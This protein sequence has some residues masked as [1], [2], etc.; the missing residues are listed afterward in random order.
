MCVH[1]AC[2]NGNIRLT[3]KSL[4]GSYV[5]R[6]KKKIYK[7]NTDNVLWQKISSRQTN[8]NNVILLA[9]SQR[10]N[11]N[12]IN[13]NLTFQPYTLFY[14]V[15]KR[16]FSTLD[17]NYPREVFIENDYCSVKLNFLQLSKQV[18]HINNL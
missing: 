5:N 18:A 13:V 3:A 6:V 12:N 8:L 17:E 2:M 9:S 10:T 7:Y 15:N 4:F 11:E 16:N 1:Y 14:C